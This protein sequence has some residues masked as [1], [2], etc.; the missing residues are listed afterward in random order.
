M[1]AD[2]HRH[3]PTSI[4]FWLVVYVFAIGMLGTTLPTPLYVLYQASWH[5]SEGIVT[6]IYATYAARAMSHSCSPAGRPT[7]WAGDR[8]SG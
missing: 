3:A 1:A 4:A 6:V 5:F 2:R 7:R 8:S